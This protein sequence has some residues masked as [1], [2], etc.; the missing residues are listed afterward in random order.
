MTC[1]FEFW[2]NLRWFSEFRW[3]LVDFP[4]LICF[5]RLFLLRVGGPIIVCSYY[6]LQCQQF[7]TPISR[8]LWICG[9]QLSLY[10]NAF[11][12]KS[13]WCTFNFGV[14]VST[15]YVCQYAY[16]DENPELYP[17]AIRVDTKNICGWDYVCVCEMMQCFFCAYSL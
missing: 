8:D 13:P 1:D 14:Y 6:F 5:F 17:S 12:T 4:C 10:F 15:V 11:C 16:K 9:F 3:L 2:R 7:Y